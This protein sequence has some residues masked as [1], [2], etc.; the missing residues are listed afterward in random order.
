[1]YPLRSPNLFTGSDTSSSQ[2]RE[3]LTANLA[4]GSERQSVDHS[5]TDGL[6]TSSVHG[7]RRQPLI[8]ISLHPASVLLRDLPEE[9]TDAARPF[10]LRLEV[11]F[12]SFVSGGDA[13]DQGP[14]KT[15]R[16]YVPLVAVRD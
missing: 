7:E 11:C 12:S 13:R 1:M 14:S 16:Y 5:T 4:Q 2:P 6:N 9:T 10:R 3:C 8:T 15:L